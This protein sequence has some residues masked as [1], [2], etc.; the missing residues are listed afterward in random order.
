MTISKVYFTN[1][2]QTVEASLEDAGRLCP[3]LSVFE[4]HRDPSS[5]IL[6]QLGRVH[7]FERFDD[8]GEVNEET[9]DHIQL[10]EP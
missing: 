6:P 3:C 1:T 2:T 10:V 7:T 8:D 5:D 4:Q 9:E